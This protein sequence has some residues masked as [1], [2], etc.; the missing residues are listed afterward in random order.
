MLEMFITRA[1]SLPE[2]QKIE[3]VEKI[4]QGKQ[5]EEK[6]KTIQ[7]FVQN[8]YENTRIADMDERLKMFDMTAEELKKKN[9]AMINFAAELEKEKSV[10]DDRYKSFVGA[11]YKLRPLFIRG[12]S[13]WKKQG[14]YPDANGTL[15]FNWGEIKGYSPR[16]AVY[17]DYVTTLK[18][19]MEKDTGTEPLTFR[20]FLKS[21]MPA[22]ILEGMS[23]LEEGTWW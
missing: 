12:I 15:R 5:G 18:G 4:V 22:G 3:A 23:I 8:L 2:G 19:V 17:Y 13:E 11:V 6:K 21:Y 14:L 16:D 20:R 1:A 9:D 10:I 7:Q